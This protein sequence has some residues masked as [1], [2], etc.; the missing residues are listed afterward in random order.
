MKNNMCQQFNHHFT[1]NGIGKRP[2]DLQ[3]IHIDN[4]LELH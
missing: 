4:Y 3:H 1:S 2:Q